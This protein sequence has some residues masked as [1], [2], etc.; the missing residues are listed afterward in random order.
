MYQLNPRER[1]IEF[2]VEDA[3]QTMDRGDSTGAG[4]GDGKI[5]WDEVVLHSE[6][7]PTRQEFN[8]ADTNDDGYVSREELR[9]V[10]Q[11]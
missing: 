9:N 4:S 1:A 6:N 2:V 3:F 5:S 11:N 10:I 7:P 8:E